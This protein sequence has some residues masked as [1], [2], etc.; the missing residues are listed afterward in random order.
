MLYKTTKLDYFS[1][2][3]IFIRGFRL[4]LFICPE[5]VTRD[6]NKY[7]ELLKNE[8]IHTFKSKPAF[9]FV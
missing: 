8:N 4:H 3:I 2:V 1:F 5:L 6:I 7:E 9:C